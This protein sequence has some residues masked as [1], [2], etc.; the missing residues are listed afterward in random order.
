MIGELILP[1]SEN[2]LTSERANMKNIV[3]A[4]LALVWGM[5]IFGMKIH[6]AIKRE[7]L[8]FGP[9]LRVPARPGSCFLVGETD[10]HADAFAVVAV[11]IDNGAPER[12]VAYSWTSAGYGL[13]RRTL[14]DEG[15]ILREFENCEE[16][17]PVSFD[18]GL[19]LVVASTNHVGVAS[20]SV[21][22]K[23]EVGALTPQL[24]YKK[25]AGKGDTS[26]KPELR[27]MRQSNR[28][29]GNR[30]FA[31]AQ[32]HSGTVVDSR[33][34]PTLSV[35]FYKDGKGRVGFQY[36]VLSPSGSPLYHGES[37][38]ETDKWSGEA[39]ALKCE[40][41]DGAGELGVTMERK[42]LVVSGVDMIDL[43]LICHYGPCRYN[44][45]FNLSGLDDLCQESLRTEE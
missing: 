22:P 19:F 17:L 15:Y 6:C 34:P 24:L 43:S 1:F 18:A 14:A 9:G 25:I 2:V 7:C 38:A 10:R 39:V 28:I 11:E 20:L 27:G 41:I 33:K 45:I 42:S 32:G 23:E 40:R 4:G 26:F 5:Q 35:A 36:K 12:L 16:H 13:A 44:V 21:T 30:P 37:V 8:V 31:V 29:C 3:V